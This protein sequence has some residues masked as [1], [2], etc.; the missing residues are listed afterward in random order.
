MKLKNIF[1]EFAEIYDELEAS[2]TPSIHKIIPIYDIMFENLRPSICESEM[3]I[4][5]ETIELLKRNLLSNVD[6]HY[7]TQFRM[8]YEIAT[9]LDPTFKIIITK[10]LTQ[11][12]LD[13]AIEHGI[14]VPEAE[15]ILIS[16][17]IVQDRN[18]AG[19]QRSG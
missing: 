11:D 15:V 17:R 4:E 18:G 8:E 16:I 19:A 14:A 9:F 10:D 5:D 2:N 12:I 3:T 6:S 1:G 7:K 13:F